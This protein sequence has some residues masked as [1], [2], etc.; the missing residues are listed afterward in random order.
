MKPAQQIFKQVE[1][2]TEEAEKVPLTH[3][4]RGY[5]ALTLDQFT[6][7][8]DHFQK[9]LDMDSGN[10]V[11]ANNRAICLLYTCDLTRAISSL[12]EFIFK[13]PE[14]NLNETLIFNLCT[15]YDLKSDNSPEKKKHILSLVGKYA[16]DHFDYSVI[17]LAN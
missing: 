16:P 10:V 15:L 5:V 13:S 14:T 7:A 17:K 9:V 8:I 2:L 12:E 1:T 3:L 11:A 6:T 4:N